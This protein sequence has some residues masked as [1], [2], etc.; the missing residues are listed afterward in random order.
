MVLPNW[1]SSAE[2][3]RPLLG[4]PQ[5]G[6]HHPSL[7]TACTPLRKMESATLTWRTRIPNPNSCT[8]L[9]LKPEASAVPVSQYLN[10]LNS[11][12]MKKSRFLVSALILSVSS[13][14][15]IYP[16]KMKL[17]TKS[18]TR[19]HLQNR[20]QFLASKL[21]LHLL[22][23]LCCK[24]VFILCFLCNYWPWNFKTVPLWL[25]I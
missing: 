4:T 18:Q 7:T 21:M 1:G 16:Q 8:K 2:L 25:Q 5:K 24:Q 15:E 23:R 22:D 17:F 9:K 19:T 10:F 13:A 20:Q 12:L 11:H 6:W 14:L 3:L